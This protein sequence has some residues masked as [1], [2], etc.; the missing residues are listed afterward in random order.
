M[1]GFDDD[2]I[3]KQEAALGLS[4]E[5]AFAKHEERTCQSSLA[6]LRA[7]K[8]LLLD[9]FES[10]YVIVGIAGASSIVNELDQ[11]GTAR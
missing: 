6:R 3:D 1:I 4:R 5:L 10:N 11:A 9:D 8:P 7:A 2:K